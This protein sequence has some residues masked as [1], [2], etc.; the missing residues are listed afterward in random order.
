MLGKKSDI[1]HRSALSKAVNSWRKRI[2]QRAKGIIF[3]ELIMK[4]FYKRM[5]KGRAFLAF[6]LKKKRAKK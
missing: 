3:L 4:A 6:K 2:R 1:E 5:A